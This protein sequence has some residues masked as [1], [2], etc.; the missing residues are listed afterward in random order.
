METPGREYR[1]QGIRALEENAL[2]RALDL[3]SRAVM[4]DGRD[5]EA[6]CFLAVVYSRKGL[7]A[8]A[9]RTIQ[10]AL[11]LQPGNADFRYWLGTILERDGD[12]EGAAIAYRECLRRRPDHAS[13]A[14]RLELMGV[15]PLRPDPVSE[16]PTPRRRSYA[17]LE[18]ETPAP[19]IPAPASPLTAPTPAAT[20][21]VGPR[22]TVQCPSCHE[23]SKPGL[24]CE[25]CSGPLRSFVPPPY[26]AAPAPGAAPVPAPGQPFAPGIPYSSDLFPYRKAHRSG[27]VLTLGILGVAINAM[28][29][30]CPPLAL[31]GLFCSAPIGLIFSIL[32]WTLGNA[33]LAEMDAGLMDPRGR[34]TTQ[35]G[36]V[37]GI[38]GTSVAAFVLAG[39]A[40]F[41][42]AMLGRTGF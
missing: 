21:R 24:S 33:D 3:L 28:A 4:A 31:M 19:A 36:R 39:W 42:L 29:F 26:V 27:S 10:N 12:T 14:A 11:E 30:L 8:Q 9:R 37:L 7:G 17:P 20:P 1:E 5:A 18:E 13:A 23:W 22:G 16:P 6:K 2:D 41:I 32:A 35:T 15:E 38:V 25:W 40:L 34:S